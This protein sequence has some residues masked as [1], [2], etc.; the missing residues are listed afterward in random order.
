M[1]KG[2][3]A[4]ARR[5][6]VSSSRHDLGVLQDGGTVRR[7]LR[8]N[9]G[10]QDELLREASYQPETKAQTVV[11]EVIEIEPQL[12]Q[13]SEFSKTLEEKLRLRWQAQE[14]KI[15]NNFLRWKRKSH[16]CS[17]RCRQ[18]LNAWMKKREPPFLEGDQRLKALELESM[19]QKDRLKHLESILFAIRV[20]PRWL[21]GLLV[22]GLYSS[23]A[24]AATKSAKEEVERQR[25]Q[26]DTMLGTLSDGVYATDM[27]GNTRSSM[28][29]PS[30]CWAG[31][32]KSW[33]ENKP[34]SPFTTPSRMGHDPRDEC[35]LIA[36]LR[37]GVSLDG[38]EHFVDRN[39]KCFPISYRSKP[40]LLNGKVVGSLVSFQDISERQASES[41]IRLQQAALREIGQGIFIASADATQ[42]GPTIEYVNPAFTEITGYAVQEVLGRL[43]SH[44]GSFR[45]ANRAAES[46]LC[47]FDGR[48]GIYRRIHSTTAAKMETTARSGTALLTGARR[49]GAHYTLHRVADRH[50]SAQGG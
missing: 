8:L 32:Q 23:A 35:P 29:R 31:S 7:E 17:S 19:Q 28:Q 10:G 20:G 1:S 25:L 6:N 13:L 43:N 27:Q 42:D 49:A 15:A 37:E 22:H 24:L 33:W 16:C 40:L 2:S 50:W 3:S 46:A 36:V 12:A 14:Q 45:G 48:Q 41:R 26:S 47:R 30:N 39:S 34:T 9:V 38:E 5:W 44:V 21:G 11:M 18:I 4:S